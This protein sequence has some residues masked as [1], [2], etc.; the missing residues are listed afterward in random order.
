MRL[1]LDAH[2]SG[3]VI[4]ASLRE[5]GH[6]VLSLAERTDLEALA[7]RQVLEMATREKRVLVTFDVKD[8]APL[9]REWGEGGHS[10]PGV[11]LVG[12]LDHRDFGV[13]LRGLNRLLAERPRPEDWTD[14]AVFLTRRS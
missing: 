10:H 12:G 9:L 1:L 3:R 13:L 11:I 2:I 7:D 4:A 6:D 14:I 8:F 5:T